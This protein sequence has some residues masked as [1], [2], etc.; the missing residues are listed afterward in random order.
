[1]L[2]NYARENTYLQSNNSGQMEKNMTIET[3]K[4]KSYIHLQQIK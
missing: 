4:K 3:G 2:C 1:M